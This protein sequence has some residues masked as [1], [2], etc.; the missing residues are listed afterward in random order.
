MSWICAETIENRYELYEKLKSRFGRG[1]D[2]K[3]IDG[4]YTA[5]CKCTGFCT[6]EIHEGFISHKLMEEH[7]CKDRDCRHFLKK[8]TKIR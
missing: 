8:P 5:S 2:L 4:K 1:H 3:C 7:H 6:F